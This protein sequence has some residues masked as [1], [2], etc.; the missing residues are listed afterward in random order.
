MND[1]MLTD[2]DDLTIMRIFL[3][4]CLS[5]CHSSLAPSVLH[6]QRGRGS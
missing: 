3:S 4:V 6:G 2:G 5:V 1:K